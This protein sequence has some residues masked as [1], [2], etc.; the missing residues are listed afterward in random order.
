MVSNGTGLMGAV[1]ITNMAVNCISN[2]GKYAYATNN[3]LSGTVSMFSVGANGGLTLLSPSTVST[4]ASPQ[5]C[6]AIHPAGTFLY[7]ASNNI[8]SMYSIANSQLSS[9][10]VAVV[11]TTINPQSIAID[12]VGT[13]VY[14]SNWSSSTISMFSIN[15]EGT[16]T[17]LR[18]SPAGTKLYGIV[19]T[20]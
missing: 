10:R 14:V 4:G 3:N 5:A 1:N 19:A 17:A 9:L 6:I 2:I 13:F 12:P 16:L 7:V 15:T 11:N 8:V 20:R 18:A